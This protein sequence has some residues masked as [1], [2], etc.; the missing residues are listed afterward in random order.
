MSWLLD[1]NVVS[2]L[3]RGPK[4]HPAVAAWLATID[5]RDTYLSVVCLGEIQTG[6]DLKL[7][8]DP[9]AGSV[10]SQWLTRLLRDYAPRILPLTLE[11]ALLWG[12][13]EA[14]RSLSTED[15]LQAATA[16]NRG[17]TFVTRNERDLA[18]LPVSLL[19]PW[20][21]QVT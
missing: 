2:E 8:K 7:R 6:V 10:L 16:S 14:I 18:G 17:F 9:A 1:T 4:M 20:Q 21:F 13:W 11:D 5:R 15:A 19:N 3:R 12:G